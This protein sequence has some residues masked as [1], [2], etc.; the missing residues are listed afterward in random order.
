MS[1]PEMNDEPMQ[2]EIIAEVR[3]VRDRLA[4]EFGYD[5][6]RLFEEMKRR[7]MASD[8][9]KIAPSPKRLSPAA[10]A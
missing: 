3:R 7:E 9:E 4:A 8:R 5:L 6:D 1:L 10:S 2:D